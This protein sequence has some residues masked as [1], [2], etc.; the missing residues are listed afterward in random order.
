MWL[1]SSSLFH[2]GKLHVVFNIVELFSK[3]M[4]VV[5]WKGVCTGWLAMLVASILQPSARAALTDD[6]GALAPDVHGECVVAAPL[7]FSLPL[8]ERKK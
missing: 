2:P 5:L 7:E 6:G 1:C 4:T 8:R 3:A